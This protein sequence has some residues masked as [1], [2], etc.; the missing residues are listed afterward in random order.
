[1]LISDPFFQAPNTYY[2]CLGFFF[3]LFPTAANFGFQFYPVFFSPCLH[4][5]KSPGLGSDFIF[6]SR[7]KSLITLLVF[8]AFSCYQILWQTVPVCGRLCI[9]IPKSPFPAFI[10]FPN[11]GSFDP[12]RMLL[13]GM[14]VLQSGLAGGGT[15]QVGT[16]R[17]DK[18]SHLPNDKIRS[19]ILIHPACR[20]KSRISKSR[21]STWRSSCWTWTPPG[22]GREWL[23]SCF[24]KDKNSQVIGSTVED[25]S[26]S[27]GTVA[28]LG[29]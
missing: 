28:P 12:P 6:P 20:W 2:C 19:C 15:A 7:N 26:Q 14:W 29:Q 17:R 23:Q 1:M 27:P 4:L 16:Q 18:L 24:V 10:Q 25:T 22:R 11:A 5:A 8:G 13:S 9:A 21:G 3:L